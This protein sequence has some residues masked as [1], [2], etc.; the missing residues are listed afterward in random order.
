ML[1]DIA[2]ILTTGERAAVFAQGPTLEE[3]EKR[4]SV[5]LMTGRQIIAIDN[6]TN[7]L[8][9]DL[10]NQSLTQPKVD[11]RVLGESR[12][13]TVRCSAVNTATGNNL[14]L[15]GDLTRRSLIARLDPKTERPELRQFPYDPLVDARDH[16]AELVA[17]A[18]TI[19]K[20][21][22]VAGMPDRPPRL[23]SF[24]DW[25]DTVRG[26]LMWIGLEDP[27]ATQDRLREND[28]KLTTLI[29]V[30]TVWR[31]AFGAVA[32]TVARRWRRRRRSGGSTRRGTSNWSRSTPTLSTPSWRSPAA[33]RR[34][35]RRLWAIIS[36]PR[37]TGWSLWR[38]APES[39]LKGR[40]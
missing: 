6:I 15:V 2:S 28:P 36:A 1:V 33:A 32:T 27:A 13:I 35:I 21:Y 10:L 38:R 5:Q 18:L 11:L 12:K 26:A 24:E 20:A 9:G 25:S 30:T 31:K 23:Q 14:K 7:E 8:D 3:F 29:R 34:S 40:E 19:L 4:L 16:R 17:A 22:C 39:G 37:P